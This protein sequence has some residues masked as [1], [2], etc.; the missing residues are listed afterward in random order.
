M[1]RRE[2]LKALGVVPAIPLGASLPVIPDNHFPKIHPEMT[3]TEVRSRMRKYY[4]D[5]VWD[6]W[7]VDTFARI[8]KLAQV[9]RSGL[10]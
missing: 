5:W 9:K 10:L 7:S 3:A 1:K 2:F 6:D 4:N 8:A